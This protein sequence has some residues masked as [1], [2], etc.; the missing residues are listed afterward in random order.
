[1]KNHPPR[2]RLRIAR[3]INEMLPEGEGGYEAS[4]A[5]TDREA[6]RLL[7][8]WETV[9]HRSDGT[10]IARVLAARLL[11]GRELV[12]PVYAARYRFSEGTCVKRAVLE[13]LLEEDGGST[14]CRYRMSSVLSWTVEPGGR[15]RA[16][17]EL[18][19]QITELDGR[20]AA[21]REA[22]EFP[23]PLRLE[24]S[25]DGPDLVLEE[26]SDRIRL[27]RVE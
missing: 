24:Y 17:V 19:Y 18:G 14:A 1:M 20:P 27:R 13:G 25:F 10:E 16:S 22:P 4:S 21:V 15:L 5:Y 2:D 12:N 11:R 6:K 23:P 26:G 3:A 8:T 9:E 7:G